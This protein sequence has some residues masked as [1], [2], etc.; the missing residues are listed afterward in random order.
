ME[1]KD[2]TWLVQ[3]QARTHRVNV[4]LLRMTTWIIIIE[5]PGGF[6]KGQ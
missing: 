5:E 3:A 2:K 4:E 1:R 6:H